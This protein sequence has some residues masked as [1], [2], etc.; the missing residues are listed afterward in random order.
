MK[1]TNN[2]GKY[3]HFFSRDLYSRDAK[4]YWHDL[5]PQ[6][7]NNGIQSP[8]ENRVQS[9]TKVRICLTRLSPDVLLY[10][11][12]DCTKVQ[13]YSIP[14]VFEQIALCYPLDL[15][16]KGEDY[17]IQVLAPQHFSTKKQ[18]IKILYFLQSMKTNNNKS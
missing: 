13:V 8:L 18:H 10:H 16:D 3:K 1:I 17:L 15:V 12:Y 6:S 11:S 4:W 7:H 2:I 14:D 5:K 9:R